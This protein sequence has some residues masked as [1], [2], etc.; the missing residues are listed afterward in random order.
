MKIINYK[1]EVDMH[2]KEEKSRQKDKILRKRR[3]KNEE[4]EIKGRT[5]EMI[6]KIHKRRK[7]V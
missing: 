6:N 5:K 7:I 2:K 3:K 4:R 1:S